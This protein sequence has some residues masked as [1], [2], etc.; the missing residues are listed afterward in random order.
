[1]V[2]EEDG[3]SPLFHCGRRQPGWPVQ[4]KARALRVTRGASRVL[5]E[6]GEHAASVSLCLETEAASEDAASLDRSKSRYR[7]V[8]YLEQRRV[9]GAY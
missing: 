3:S 7:D 4:T 6:V 1:M 2:A 9:S 8:Y 5:S